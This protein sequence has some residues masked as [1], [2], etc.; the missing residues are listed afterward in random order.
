MRWPSALATACSALVLVSCGGEG[1]DQADRATTVVGPSI[2][3]AVA[4]RLAQR[5]DRVAA[6]LDAGDH[7]AARKEAQKLR[8]ELS[9]SVSE[10]PPVYLEDLSGLVNEIEVQIPVCAQIPPPLK[11][12]GD[13]DDDD[14]KKGKGKGKGTGKG[15]GKGDD[16]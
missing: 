8:A 9:G 1:E 6:H 14:G 7:C 3:A 16:D 4:E 2:P 15:K 12:R 5:S 13:D 11:S 10:I